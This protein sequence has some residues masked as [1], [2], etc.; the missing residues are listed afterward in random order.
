MALF[1]RLRLQTLGC[2]FEPERCHANGVMAIT[3]EMESERKKTES[4]NLI[5]SPT[6]SNPG[7]RIGEATLRKACQMEN[8]KPTAAEFVLSLR[9]L[10]DFY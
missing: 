2:D 5:P 3:V 9:E 10:A 1:E 4:D 8:T 6:T 7:E